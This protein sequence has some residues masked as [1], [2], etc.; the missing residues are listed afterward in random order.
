MAT[1]KPLPQRR[2]AIG[3]PLPQRCLAV[4][5]E[6]VAAK[7]SGAL[8]S[9]AE[10]KLREE[11][12]KLYNKLALPVDDVDHVLNITFGLA[13]SQI[14]DVNEK[15]QIMT[16]KVWL[17]HSWSDS[18]M[19]WTPEDYGGIR[20]IRVPAQLLWIPDIL[21]Y[22]NAD[23]TY[24][25]QNMAMA[26]VYYNGTVSWVP[27]AI[28]KSSCKINVEY[29]PFDE[30]VCKMKFGAWTYSGTVVDLSPEGDKATQRDYWNSGE[31]DIVQSPGKR[32]VVKYPCCDDIYVDITFDFQIR[33][34]PLF[35]V[36]NLLLPCALISFCSVLVFYLPSDCGEKMSLCTSV[37]V[38]LSVFLLLI[39]KLI[40]ANADTMPLITKYLLFT[41]VLVT[42]SIVISVFV[43]NIH[44]RSPST[45]V[46]SPWV[47]R[48]FIDTLPKFLCMKRPDNYNFRYKNVGIS[49][50]KDA[51]NNK[52][53]DSNRIVIES[54]SSSNFTVRMR[55][56]AD[57]MIANNGDDVTQAL[58]IPKYLPSS[59][60]DGDTNDALSVDKAIQ[61]IMYITS[62][63]TDEEDFLRLREDWKYVA[64]VI[65]RIFLVIFC[66]VCLSGTIGILLQAPLAG[67]FFKEQLFG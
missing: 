62:T 61:E 57:G 15:S 55:S 41:M 26:N 29:F 13:I 38:S 65:D 31:W 24:D 45:H 27:P 5:G 52:R 47:R 16:T 50:T 56:N 42:S 48:I 10:K 44:H 43:L 17:R 22:N 54:P 7:T 67:K 2:M 20:N 49:L 32:N 40:P 23:G 9:E 33:R 18:H 60:S 66:S 8:A 63:Y 46:M 6:T 59:V 64:M 36:A 30:Q 3:K 35:Y 28:Y 1:E 25:V 37:L 58:P 4:D 39:T 21:I 34:K 53:V 51:I 19:K 11:L 12:F 14:I